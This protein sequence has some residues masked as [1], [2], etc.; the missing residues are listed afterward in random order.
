MGK[1]LDVGW[2]LNTCY[3]PEFFTGVWITREFEH[4]VTIIVA[5]Q[6]P[7]ADVPG[8]GARL[9][10]VE[11]L[12]WP[13]QCLE[14]RRRTPPGQKDIKRCTR[15]VLMAAETGLVD[16]CIVD[17]NDIMRMKVRKKIAKHSVLDCP[18]RAVQGVS[19]RLTLL[20][21]RSRSPVYSRFALLLVS[22]PLYADIMH[23]SSVRQ[24]V[25]Y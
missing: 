16:A 2:N 7:Q 13:D 15:A 21:A 4:R 1:L 18:S 12:Q 3:G 14:S 17:D 10:R 23:R 25:L 24:S 19:G 11:A 5:F 22:I 6:Q 8:N 20:A 9:P